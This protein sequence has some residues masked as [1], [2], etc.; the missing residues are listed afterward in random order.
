[1]EEG[2]VERIKILKLG[3]LEET[4]LMFRDRHFDM[5]D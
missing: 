3:I 2:K 4:N 5:N 1:M